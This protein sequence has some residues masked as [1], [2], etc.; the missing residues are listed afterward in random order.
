LPVNFALDHT[1]RSPYGGTVNLYI[2]PEFETVVRAAFLLLCTGLA[3]FIV[4]RYVPYGIGV[5]LVGIVVF[6]WL[7]LTPLMPP[8]RLWAREGTW[9]WQC[10]AW[11]LG[12]ALSAV[13][14]VLL[15]GRLRRSRPVV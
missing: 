9:V 6:T 7:L 15:G 12:A 10:M 2:I 8:Q 14:L 1:E 11:I 4:A 5:A 13:L 3:G